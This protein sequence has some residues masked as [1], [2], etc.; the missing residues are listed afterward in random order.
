[1]EKSY[2]KPAIE[3]LPLAVELPVAA[4]NLGKSSSS[5]I[6]DSGDI[7]GKERNFM[8]DE[9]SVLDDAWNGLF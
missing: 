2:I 1:M 8:D 9:T 5:P 7:L 6:T 4:T 3:V